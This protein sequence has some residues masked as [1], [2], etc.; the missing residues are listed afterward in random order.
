MHPMAK[1]ANLAKNHQRIGE[2]VDEIKRGAPCKSGKKR[3]G[4]GKYSSWM[5]KAKLSKLNTLDNTDTE[6]IFAFRF[7]LY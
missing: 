7:R 2:N 4:F 3:H 1:M 5:P 6:T